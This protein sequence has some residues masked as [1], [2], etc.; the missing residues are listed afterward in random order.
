MLVSYKCCENPQIALFLN[1]MV[2]ICI[3]WTELKRLCKK[4]ALIVT[5]IL[6][7]ETVCIYWNRKFSYCE[8]RA[9]YMY[10]SVNT[11][12]KDGG[13]AG[14]H[15]RVELCLKQAC[16]VI[17]QAGLAAIGPH[18]GILFLLSGTFSITFHTHIY[19]LCVPHTVGSVSSLSLTA[20]QATVSSG[21]TVLF[22][23]SSFLDV[24]V[25]PVNIASLL[26]ALQS[27]M[28]IFQY[29]EFAFVFFVV[30]HQWLGCQPAFWHR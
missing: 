13:W 29:F 26:H 17:T 15:Y 7:F 20:C 19:W 6:F 27:R 11:G 1:R 8:C 2:R 30:H 25:P 18:I 23:F 9:K 4:N 12:R 22:F 24:S 5:Y 10:L 21:C 14:W 16:Y 3:K 28:E